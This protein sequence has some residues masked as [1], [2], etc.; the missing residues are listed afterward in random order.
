VG[1]SRIAEITRKSLWAFPEAVLQA[2]YQL[3]Q[4]KYHIVSSLLVTLD[5]L[6]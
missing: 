6:K 1:F 3:R 5:I 4:A 2:V